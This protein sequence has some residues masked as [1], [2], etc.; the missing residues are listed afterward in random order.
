MPQEINKR[1]TIVAVAREAGVSLSTVSRVMNGNPT[2]DPGLAANVR[3]I[4]TALGYSPSALARSLVLGKTM[5]VGVVVPD[6]G[7]PTFQ[8]IL[9]GANHASASDGYRLIIA[10][11]E[12][13]ATEEAI[14][15]REIRRRSDAVIVVA[16]RMPQA[17]LITL[18]AEVRPLVLVNRALD[19]AEVPQLGAD[20]ESGIMLLARHV[21]GLGHRNV[22]FLEGTTSSASNAL[23]RRGLTTVFAQQPEA[24]LTIL[25]CGTSFADG[26][27]IADDAMATGATA[28]LAFNDLVAMGLMSSLNQRGVRVPH[29]VSL[30]G[31]DD[32]MFARYLTP[33]LT[34][35]SVE[36]VAIGEAAWKMALN[37][38]SANEAPAPLR[39]RP[40]LEVRGSTAPPPVGRR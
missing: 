12:E 1:A 3:R 38:L 27:V 24:E 16:P 26:Y 15:V 37:A 32:I 35:A 20:Y 19:D 7:N 25:A 39:F 2:V 40:R 18:A 21:L 33:P 14:L 6:L 31:F 29:D 22:L 9:H 30:T 28:I 4:A 10:D 36:S 8:G 13:D 17:E 23:R 5:T 34:T 11:S